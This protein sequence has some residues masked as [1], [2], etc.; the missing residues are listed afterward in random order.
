MSI[1]LQPNVQV[2]WRRETIGVISTP[3]LELFRPHDVH[4][5]VTINRG[6]VAVLNGELVAVREG[7]FSHFVTPVLQFSGH[8]EE[9]V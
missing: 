8:G 4:R 2:R 1:R 6:E 9:A 5:P 3:P 7:D